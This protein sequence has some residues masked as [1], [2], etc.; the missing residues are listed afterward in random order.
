MISWLEVFVGRLLGH[1]NLEVLFDFMSIQDLLRLSACNSTLQ[2]IVQTYKATAWDIDDFLRSWFQYPTDF[3]HHLGQA[4]AIMTGLSLFHFLDRSPRKDSIL[5]IICRPEGVHTL[6]FWLL[7]SGYR[8]KSRGRNVSLDDLLPYAVYRYKLAHAMGMTKESDSPLFTVEFVAIHEADVHRGIRVG[9]KIVLEV[10]EG[11]P[12]STILRELS[13]QFHLFLYDLDAD[14]CSASVSGNNEF[15]DLGPNCFPFS[16]IYIPRPTLLFDH[17]HRRCK[18][19]RACRVSRCW[20]ADGTGGFA[21]F[22]I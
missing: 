14:E 10:T 7:L 22:A 21:A 19:R 9:S 2:V 3:R 8:M 6:S 15:H 11:D 16:A 4:D 17:R 1:S 18:R 5:R 20:T 13:S 12:R